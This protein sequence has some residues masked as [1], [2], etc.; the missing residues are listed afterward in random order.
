MWTNLNSD[1]QS[2]ST[3]SS[4]PILGVGSPGTGAGCPCYGP[5]GVALI[6]VMLA[7]L[8]LTV[9]AATIVFTARAE[10]FASQ[11]Y[12]LDT[13]A[14]YLAKAGIQR[15]INWFRSNHYLAVSQSQ[16]GTYY[17]V[18]PTPAPF[19]LW[20]SDYSPVKCKAAVLGGCPSGNDIVQLVGYGSGV[21]GLSSSNY[22]TA[23]TNASGTQIA[24][25]FANDLATPSNTRVSGDASDS[26]Y[27]KVT[28]TLLNYQTVNVS[29]APSPVPLACV[30]SGTTVTCP[31]ETWLISSKAYW[32]GSDAS[33]ATT[34]AAEETAIIQP[35][36][37]P[38]WGN[39]LYGYCGVTLGG[40]SGTCTDAFNSALGAYGGGNGSVASGACGSATTNVIA[41]GAGVG[42]NGYVNLSSNITIGGNVTIG[43]NPMG[44][45]SCCTATSNPH[46]GYNPP[47]SG[48]P[49]LGEVINGP[50]IDPPTLPTIP[51]LSSATSY[52]LTGGSP[53]AIIPDGAAQWGTPPGSAPPWTP[54]PPAVNPPLSS[55]TYGGSCVSGSTCDGTAANPY[56][57]KDI[58]MTNNSAQLEIVGGTDALHPVYYDMECLTQNGGNIYISGYVVLNIQ[59][60]SSCG[61]SFGGNGVGNG[62][63]S[64]VPPEELVINYEGTNAVSVG[65]SAAV[66]AVL[67]AP[68]ADVTLGGGGSGGYWV[69]SVQAKTV[70]VQGG[71]PIH[72]DV[73]LS[74][75]GGNLGTIVST[76]YS[77]KKM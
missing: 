42:S 30:T 18:S 39:A 33:T 49:V 66:S 27:F 1:R 75:I 63:S 10:S 68:N 17:Y 41:S 40:S 2:V 29:P 26:G 61:L 70:T 73:Q 14:D 19:D 32:T 69:G 45:T 65:G 21:T 35:I 46:C 31:M 72:Y 16:A 4:T 24:T 13:Q 51:S 52:S 34:A 8:V 50:H 44:G 22:P 77:R 6:L 56:L 9:L 20:T 47:S 53:K 38:T 23:I 60:T 71:Y 67:S 5:R 59:G 48:S 57:I 28:A 76:A 12:R 74:R 3:G 15:A 43:S 7:M 64:S 36:Y 37:W 58:T 55:S 54:A 62:I 25:A 11:N